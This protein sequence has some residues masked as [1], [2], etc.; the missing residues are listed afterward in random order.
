M[1]CGGHLAG[2]DQVDRILA[3]REAGFSAEQQ[4]LAYLLEAGG[5]QLRVAAMLARGHPGVGGI[6][7]PRCA[8]T[9]LRRH[10]NYVHAVEVDYCLTCSLYW[11][12][13]D[14]LEA[15]QILSERQSG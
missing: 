9:M 8:A 13:K 15:L 12:V 10:F 7:C 2:I 3:R 11:F 14:E 1:S 5:D 4:H 6:A